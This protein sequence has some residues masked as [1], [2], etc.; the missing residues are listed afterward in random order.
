MIWN[1][2]EDNKSISVIL[3]DWSRILVRPEQIKQAI[4]K[5]EFS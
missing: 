5:S 2:I 1:N 4:G 3:S